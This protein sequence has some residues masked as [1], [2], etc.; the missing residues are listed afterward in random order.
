MFNN[1]SYKYSSL[2]DDINYFY[3]ALR[4]EGIDSQKLLDEYLSK[5]FMKMSL[6][7]DDVEK[8]VRYFDVLFRNPGLVKN[9]D[10]LLE[11]FNHYNLNVNLVL[12]IANG[13]GEVSRKIKSLVGTNNA[14]NFDNDVYQAKSDMQDY[15]I[16][17]EYS[18]N[19]IMLEN[20]NK[21]FNNP[22]PLEDVLKKLSILE[23]NMPRIKEILSKNE[24]KENEFKSK[25]ILPPFNHSI[26]EIEKVSEECKELIHNM[27]LSIER[28]IGYID[29][30]KF[31]TSRAKYL[32]PLFEKI[33]IDEKKDKL[34]VEDPSL[35]SKII[36]IVNLDKE[37]FISE[38]LKISD[39]SNMG[40]NK[41]F[42]KKLEKLWDLNKRDP[43]F[44]SKLNNLE[45]KTLDGNRIN[46]NEVFKYVYWKQDGI[47][48]KTGHDTNWYYHYKKFINDSERNRV[49]LE[50]LRYVE[51]VES[52]YLPETDKYEFAKKIIKTHK[53]VI[54]EVNK[55]EKYWDSYK[56]QETDYGVSLGELCEL[57]YNIEQDFSENILPYDMH[58]LNGYFDDVKF[59]K[60]FDPQCEYNTSEKFELLLENFIA[61]NITG[62]ME[63]LNNMMPVK[64]LKLLD[65][66]FPDLNESFKSNHFSSYMIDELDLY[67]IG[68]RICK[69]LDITERDLKKVQSK[70]FSEFYLTNSSFKERDL[71]ANF[72]KLDLYPVPASQVK[73]I[74]MFADDKKKRGFRI[75][76]LLPCNVRKYDNDGNFTLEKDVI[77]V[78]EYFGFYGP[79]YEEKTIKKTE[80]QNNLERTV[81]Q[82]CLHITDIKTDNICKE[83][84]DKKIDSKCYSDYVS[85][86]FDIN[87]EHNKKILFLRTQLHNFIYTY[88]INELLW[89]IKYDYSKLNIENLE[90]VKG[91]NKSYLDEFEQLFIQCDNLKSGEI[92]R[93]CSSILSSYDIKFK[94]EQSK[95]TANYRVKVK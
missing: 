88:L 33:I 79:K 81:N 85:N 49:Y 11:N 27:G 94:K 22:L 70:H 15:E 10:K 59:K 41:E 1:R 80:W 5:I 38:Y 37:E 62:R 30:I 18:N 4:K 44:I 87:D 89:H 23:N 57:L 78:G 45:N 91:K 52:G 46:Y 21:T 12:D 47:K 82:K 69:S 36:D 29:W 3:D 35:N 7:K 39:L 60:L 51:A 20:Y 34:R 25:T 68:Q 73:N 43:L 28:S 90:L 13:S 53:F 32:K 86:N 6:P 75:D 58:I 93:R 63:I 56:D 42:I 67:G 48:K 54:F 14:S 2:I 65:Q 19:P 17:K 74:V 66:K 9:I 92:A 26:L 40:E 72:E 77:F 31:F 16:L 24:V 55:F 61:G 76:F 83:L 84:K 50:N 95:R 71:F 64:L 8:S